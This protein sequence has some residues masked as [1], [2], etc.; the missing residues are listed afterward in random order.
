MSSLTPK[1]LAACLFLLGNF[2][3]FGFEIAYRTTFY[4]KT[5]RTVELSPDLVDS[6]A[7][8]LVNPERSVAFV[9]GFSTVRFAIK[10]GDRTLYYRFPLTADFRTNYSGRRSGKKEY[11]YALLK[12]FRIYLTDGTGTPLRQQ[13]GGFPLT[14]SG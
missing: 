11:S 13:P 12:D 14:P 8:Y 9:G 5:N 2:V 6:K 3:A 4:N 1:V 7:R 10:S